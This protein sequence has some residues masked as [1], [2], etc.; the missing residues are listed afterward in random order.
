MIGVVLLL[1]MLM[2]LNVLTTS[3]NIL[4]VAG[5]V[6]AKIVCGIRSAKSRIDRASVIARF[7]EWLHKKAL[8]SAD[9]VIP[10]SY[11]GSQ[12]VDLTI[13]SG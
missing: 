9:L 11:A 5:I 1:L 6:D 12:D 4:A 7:G 3:L 13:G 8:H 10:N 2:V